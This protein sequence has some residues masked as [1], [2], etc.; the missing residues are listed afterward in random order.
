MMT[1]TIALLILTLAFCACSDNKRSDSSSSADSTA[2][3]VRETESPSASLLKVWETDTLLTTVES[4]LYDP[5]ASIIY[6][7]NIE[8]HHSTKD[9]KGS[10][11]KLNP[12][13]TISQLKWVS[14]L[15][16]PKGMTLLHDK[17][18]VTDIDELVE[19]NLA[20]GKIVKHYPVPGATFL[21]DAANDGSNVYLSDSETGKVHMLENGKISLLTQGMEGINGLAV[22]NKG[23]LF[24]LD[25]KG[26]SRYTKQD[27]DTQVIN[28]VVTGGDGLVILDDSTYLA[29]RW[30]GQI[31]LIRN[32]KEQLLLDTQADSSNTADIDY[33][34]A[35]QLLI[36]PT[37]MKNKVVAYKLSY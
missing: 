28:E 35:Q 30:Q 10:I 27:K 19:I 4:T 37:F 23:E 2:T 22:N 29:S 36:V 24:I 9:G 34:S 25:G 6:A 26:L 31:Y 21:N 7:S 20:D 32:G 18:Y 15:N 5:K 1:K 33:I 13:G 8:G 12:D 17:L 14:G 11:S 16:A 3:P